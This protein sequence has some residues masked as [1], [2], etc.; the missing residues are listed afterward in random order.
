[1]NVLIL[2]G[3]VKSQNHCGTIS[4]LVETASRLATFLD[5]YGNVIDFKAGNHDRNES[6]VPGFGVK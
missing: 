4:T 6:R 3:V 2:D 5:L 1:M